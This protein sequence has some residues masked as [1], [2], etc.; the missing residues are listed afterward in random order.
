MGKAKDIVCKTCPCEPLIKGDS[1]S[2]HCKKEHNAMK[3]D[4][5]Q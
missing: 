5:I 1:W 4:E 3:K 2:W